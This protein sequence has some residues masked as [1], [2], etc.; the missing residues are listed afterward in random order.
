MSQA[1]VALV[2]VGAVVAAMLVLP[3]GADAAF[4]G[5]DGLIAFMRAVG[6]EPGQIYLVR[7]NGRGL[8]QITHRRGGAD[9]PTWS[10]DGRRIAFSA[11]GKDGLHI[12]VK[13][14]GG[15]VRQI[16]QG[17]RTYVDPT[18]SPDGRRIAA[19][20][21][22]WDQE[23]N[24]YESIVVMRADGRRRHVVYA[25]GLR[26]TE[27]PT[28]SPDG[29][30]IAFVHTD[31]DIKGADLNIYVVP[32]G[33][34]TARRIT[35]VGSQ[36][37]PDW[38][39]DG[40]LIAYTWAYDLGFDDVRVIR[41]DATGDA[42]VTDDL[43]VSDGYPAWAPSGRRLAISRLGRIWTVAPD[44]S[45]LRQVTHGGPANLGDYDPSWQPR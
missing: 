2:A 19:V 40:R 27:S 44:G 38:S 22:H 28:W 7:P 33:G 32:A 25:G 41:P 21:G 13:R 18:W 29:Q 11:T 6:S 3:S 5:R 24:Y 17:N 4:P 16:T 30:T 14:F 31:V 9:S 10:P 26:K 45:G 39:P 35:G 34:G 23:G 42:P 36:D 15:G 43:S 1:V 8:R 37:H 20:R 12:F